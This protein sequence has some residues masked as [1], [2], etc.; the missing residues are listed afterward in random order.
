MVKVAADIKKIL[1]TT[2]YLNWC[3]VVFLCL[4]PGDVFTIFTHCLKWQ[5]K[6][7]ISLNE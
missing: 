2:E 6:E 1:I 3:N 7:I 5:W 4:Y